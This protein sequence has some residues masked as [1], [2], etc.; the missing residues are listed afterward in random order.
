[1]ANSRAKLPPSR[2]PTSN[3]STSKIQRTTKLSGKP[4]PGL[5]NPAILTGKPLFGIDFTT[6]GMLSAVF[7]KCPVFAGRVV[8]ANTDEIKAMP[9]VRHAFV[10]EGGNDLTGLLC[11]VAIVADTWWQART[12][13]Q[14]LKVQ[15]DEGKTASQSSEGFAKRADE[16][17]KQPP[18]RSLRKDGDPDAA[19]QN[20]AKVLE[21][22]YY[23]PFI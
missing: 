9:G 1:M 11:G 18:A 22:A 6:P 4:P 15:W 20:A 19:F 23:Y 2:R 21:A 7:E 12:A 10:V 13:R 17:S 3:R 8:T 5:D 16:L 14:K